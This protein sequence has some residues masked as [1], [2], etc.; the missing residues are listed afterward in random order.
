LQII[1]S[2][3]RRSRDRGSLAAKE[4]ASS[5]PQ[6]ALAS[7]HWLSFGRQIETLADQPDQWADVHN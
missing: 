6:I 4:A 2:P 1:R 5:D 3:R 7:A